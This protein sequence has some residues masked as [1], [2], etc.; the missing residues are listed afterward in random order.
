MKAIIRY[1]DDWEVPELFRF[2]TLPMLDMTIHAAPHK[3]QH[4]AVLQQYRTDLTELAT[5][6]LFDKI[7]LPIDW[8]IS[9]RVLFTNPNSPDLD[10][11]IEALYMA[12]DGKTLE[13]PSI[14]TD[15]RHIQAVQMSK[16]YS[17]APTKR[18]RPNR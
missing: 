13:G 17:A 11:T 3:R 14:L 1:Y 10:H 7:E 5:R 16:I 6:R 8:P 2:S 15:D 12:L 4:R 18:D 9:L